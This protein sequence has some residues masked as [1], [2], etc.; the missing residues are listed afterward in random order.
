MMVELTQPFVWPE[1]PEGYKEWSLDDLKESDR[2]QEKQQEVRG[3]LADA[4]VN[5]ERRERM[6]EQAKALLEGKASWKRPGNTFDTTF[7]RGS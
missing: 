5:E 4:Y 2:E 6:R 7:R 3:S 1:E